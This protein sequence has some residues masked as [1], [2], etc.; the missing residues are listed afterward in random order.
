MRFGLGDNC[1]PLVFQ[2]YLAYSSFKRVLDF[3]L[4]S[5]LIVFFSPLFFVVACLVWASMGLPIIFTQI[6]PGYKT[7]VFTLYKF[8]TMTVQR[9]ARGVILSDAQ[10]L[11]SFGRLLR[12]TS[13]DELPALINILRGEMSF[14]GPRPLLPQYIPLYSTEQARRHDVKPGFS[15][16]AQINGRNSISW[17]E[18]FRLDVW[19]VDHQSFLLDLRILLMTIWKVLRRD[20]I[21]APGEVTIAPFCGSPEGE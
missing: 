1:L 17:E 19:Y 4:A 5:I 14:I 15:G 3:L 18:K 16:W 11:T 21:S 7:S 6:R 9:D 2:R 12:A 10:R 13:I 8:R 20:G